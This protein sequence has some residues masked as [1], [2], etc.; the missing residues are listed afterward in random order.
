MLRSTAL[1]STGNSAT[2]QIFFKCS[3]FSTE[4]VLFTMCKSVERLKVTMTSIPIASLSL[5]TNTLWTITAV[6]AFWRCGHNKLLLQH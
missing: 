5:S 2:C 1:S 6:S 3:H 4:K